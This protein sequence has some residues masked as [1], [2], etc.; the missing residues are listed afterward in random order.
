ML[1]NL[2]PLVKDIYAQRLQT[3]DDWD[4]VARAAQGK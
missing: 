3:W 2:L 1:G 4:D